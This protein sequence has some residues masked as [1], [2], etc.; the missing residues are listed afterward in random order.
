VAGKSSVLR[1]GGA[2]L[3]LGLATVLGSS[4]AALASPP[5]SHIHQVACT[6]KAF[7]VHYDGILRQAC[8]EGTGTI[9]VSIPA[10]NR[11]TT[12][13]NSGRFTTRKFVTTR[14]VI[15][16]ADRTILVPGL[17]TMESITISRVGARA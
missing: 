10:V 2:G 1:L 15:F 12:G 7:T 14:V 8:Y 16:P 6:A 3:A 9:R 5:V 13:E 17:P 4:A 11:V